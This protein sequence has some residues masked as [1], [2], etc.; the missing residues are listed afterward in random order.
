MVPARSRFHGQEKPLA[1][2]VLERVVRREP[3]AMEAFFE[4]YYDRVYAHVVNL[5]RDPVLGQD[6]TQEVFLRLHRAVKHLDP[7]RD[8][9]SDL[10]QDLK[11]T[12]VPLF[13]ITDRAPE[14]DDEGHLHYGYDRSAS[15]AFGKAVVDLG[16]DRT[17]EELLQASRTQRRL[18]SVS[19]ELGGVEEIVRGP[20][21][22]VPFR[23]I[24][25]KIVEEPGL[26]AQSKAATEAFRRVMVRQLELTQ[27]KEIFLFVHGFR[28]SFEDAAFAMA[29]LWHFL[30]R[31]GVPIIY[32]WPAGY[33]G[34]FGYTYDRE[35]SEFTVYHLR[36][37]LSAMAS[38]PEVEKIHLI[39]HSRGTDVAVAAMRELT[40]EARAA[41]ID[42]R[43]KYKLHNVI[44][45]DVLHEDVR[46]FVK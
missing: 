42:P 8:Y 46:P 19:L 36:R 10:A 1:S 20:D 4:H 30:G 39:A 5:L 21:I 28:N 7:Q 12:E 44:L 2:A 3:D 18:K 23:E 31:I 41:G 22:P 17:W 9:Y 38:F 34:I 6:L 27:R 45:A 32:T 33:P 14:Q 16:K 40:I 25:G 29:E 43:K 13:Y 26:V 35:S 37:A 24:D 15:L 11:R